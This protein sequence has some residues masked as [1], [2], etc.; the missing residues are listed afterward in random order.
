MLWWNS[1]HTAY[2]GFVIKAW[3]ER[4]IIFQKWISLVWHCL[5]AASAHLITLV[6]VSDAFNKYIS[7]AIWIFFEF[8]LFLIDL[9]DLNFRYDLC[10]RFRRGFIKN[11][12]FILHQIT[13]SCLT[14][15]QLLFFQV[16]ELVS[17]PFKDFHIEHLVVSTL[18]NSLTPL[19]L[20]IDCRFICNL[21]LFNL[22]K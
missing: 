22:S 7:I 18:F 8:D 21:L 16:T 1:S 6:W 9:I 17:L 14:R 3:F 2:V 10:F 15:L 12:L 19:T 20:V 5:N 11:Y 13:D 4:T